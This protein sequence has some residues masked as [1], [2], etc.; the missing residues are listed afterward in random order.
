MLDDAAYE[1]LQPAIHIAD[2]DEERHGTHSS[3]DAFFPAATAA[4]EL[5]VG[6]AFSEA[7]RSRG[8]AVP[9]V[10]LPRRPGPTPLFDRGP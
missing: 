10:D 5:D 9:E 2:S 3:S 8:P 7:L 1:S 6:T 4:V